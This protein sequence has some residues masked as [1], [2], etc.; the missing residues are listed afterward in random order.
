MSWSWGQHILLRDCLPMA[1]GNPQKNN[2]HP[3]SS[4]S[5]HRKPTTN[6]PNKPSPSNPQSNKPSPK[7][8]PNPRPE[9]LAPP[10]QPPPAYGFHM[11]DR[12]TIVLADGSARSYLAL[13]PDYQDLPLQLP[14]FPIRPPGPD[15]WL[16][17]D[18][19]SYRQQNQ[20]YWNSLGVEGSRKRKFGD[21]RDELNDEFARQRQQLLQ[22]GNTVGSHVAGPSSQDE[23]SAKMIKAEANKN[24]KRRTNEAKV[25]KPEGDYRSWQGRVSEVDQEKVKSSFLNFVRAITENANQKNKYLADG[26]QGALQCLACGRSSKDFPDVHSLIMHT[27]NPETSTSDQVPNH[28]GLHK[29]LCILMGWNY[30]M[31]PDNS[32]VYQRLSADEIAANLDDLIMWPPHVIIRNTSTGKGKDGRMEGLGNKAMDMKLRD[33]GFTTGKS[34]SMYGR[35]GHMG[36]TAVKFAGDQSGL[37]DAMRLAD[38][39]EKQKR[40]RGS[41]ASV[42]PMY[43]QGNEDE[44]DPNF[45]KLDKNGQ[46]ERI[47]YGYLGTVSDMEI[48]D[49]D[50]RRKVTIESKR[51]K[52]HH[53]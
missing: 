35:E 52:A 9:P 7:L 47:L 1:G 30:L 19:D 36:T 5:H 28:L 33:L 16:G 48:V 6:N 3:S 43:R 44:K 21:E 18:R 42:Q 49:F 20:E 41:W 50:T 11:L 23:K 4:S 24:M 34:K 13:P 8:N 39:F 51:E 38:Y 2:H 10:P 27:Y 29:A 25:I 53:S 46:K 17:L 40:G 26:K 31:P 45:V 14:R 22:Y 15:P 12:R 32:K 37:T